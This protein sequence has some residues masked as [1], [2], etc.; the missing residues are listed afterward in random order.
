ME[1]MRSVRAIAVAGLPRGAALV[2]AVVGARVHETV[3]MLVMKVVMVA[4][5]HVV[6]ARAIERPVHVPP[7][8][9]LERDADRMTR[10]HA[11]HHLR[12]Q[13]E[14]KHEAEERATHRSPSMYR[15]VCAAGQGTLVP[16]N[17]N[18][19]S[20]YDAL[21][22]TCNIDQRGKTLRLVL[23][24]FLE[25]AGLLLGVLWFFKWGPTWL[26]WPAAAIWI[27]GMFVI[28]EAVVGWCAVRAM[29]FKTPV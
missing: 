27:S 21:M 9:C 7:A 5:R 13:E 12:E 23:G 28:F 1:V 29:G 10:R 14:G 15:P 17:R 16:E 19:T 11:D 24:A 20:V 6:R 4:S 25:T 3:F 26:I 8:A 22:F 2:R 18:G